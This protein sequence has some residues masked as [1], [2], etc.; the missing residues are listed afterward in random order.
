MLVSCVLGSSRK[1]ITLSKYR[2]VNYEHDIERTILG[3]GKV[4]VVNGELV[5]QGTPEVP[6]CCFH[7]IFF[8]FSA[9]LPFEKT[10]SLW[11]DVFKLQ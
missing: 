2:A 10:K 8:S 5:M 7:S 4:G 11:T 9:S 1:V 3:K 6:H